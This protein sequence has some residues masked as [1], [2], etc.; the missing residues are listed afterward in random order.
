M[1]VRSGPMRSGR[2]CCATSSCA[3][4]AITAA[5]SGRSNIH[6]NA[7]A[8]DSGSPGRANNPVRPAT[9]NSGT[10]FT[11]VATAGT[12]QLIASTNEHGSP[13]HKLANANTS[14][15]GNNSPTSPRSPANTTRPD[16]PNR[17]TNAS[18]S[19]RNSPS[20]NQTSH[21][22]D[23]PNRANADTRSNGAFCR[24]NRA[25][26]PTTGTPSGTPNNRR[27]TRR[28]ST[29][30]DTTGSIELTNART[31]SGAAIRNRTASD[32]TNVPSVKKKSVNRPKRRST[33]NNPRRVHHD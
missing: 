19:P 12:P 13:S 23:R 8:N 26:V 15:A 2:Y 5:C 7:T 17:A 33:A 29:D 32:A 6:R 9:T 16:N 20:P 1:S 30:T 3:A 28:R 11:A 21:A 31:R 10:E 22:S 4:A 27:A 14:N 25:A 18:T 24:A